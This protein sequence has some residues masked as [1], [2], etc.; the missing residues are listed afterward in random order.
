MKRS[1]LKTGDKFKV[2]QNGR[3]KLYSVLLGTR[4]GD[5]VCTEAG[6]WGELEDLPKRSPLIV[7]LM[8]GVIHV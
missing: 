2:A 3:V 1:D 4:N 5:I 6:L 7:K 8:D